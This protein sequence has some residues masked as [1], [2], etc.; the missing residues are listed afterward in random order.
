MQPILFD[1]AERKFTTNGIGRLNCI[2]CTVT[3]ERNGVYELEMVMPI[4]AEHYNE[5]EVGESVI[6]ARHDDTGD[7]QPFDV[8]EKSAPI[9]GK[10][11]FRAHHISYRLSD[12]VV[13]PYEA[14]TCADA[15]QQI[16]NQS[17]NA[18]PFTFWTDKAVSGNFVN[19]KPS[20]ARGMLAGNEGSILDVFG[21]GEYEFDKFTVKLHL[22]R[23]TDSGV[24][25]RYGK[26]LTDIKHDVSTGETYNAIVPFYLSNDGELVTLPE[27]MLVYEGA[28]IRTTYLT[29]HDLVIIRTENNEPIEVSY[30]MIDAVPMDLSQDFSDGA[31]TVEELRNAAIAKFEN[32]GAWEPKENI[33]VNFVQ[34]WQTDQFKEFAPLQRV[35]LCDTVSVFYDALGVN[36]VKKKVIKTVYNVLL[37]RY[38][39]IELGELSTSIA[40]VIAGPIEEQLANTPT[41]SM[42]DQ[43]IDTAT[44]LIRGGLGGY[45]VMNANADGK[46]EEILIMDKPDVNEA[47]QVIRMNKN[48]IAFSSTGYNGPFLSAWTIDGAFVAD[49]ITAGTLNAN[50]IRAG[51]IADVLGNTNW[52]LETGTLTMTKG[53]ITL[54]GGNFSVND[55]GYMEAISGL[56][57][58]WQIENNQLYSRSGTGSTYYEM[59][60]SPGEIINNS[61]ENSIGSLHDLTV[62]L[63]HGEIWMQRDSTMLSSTGPAYDGSNNPV[64]AVGVYKPYTMFMNRGGNIGMWYGGGS[65][66]SPYGAYFMFGQSVKVNAAFTVTGSKSREAATEDYADRLFYCY[67]MASPMFGDVGEGVIGEDGLAYITID[68]IFS[69]AVTLT[70]YQVFLQPYG[71]GDL[72]ID[73]REPSYFV[74]KGT[75]WL[76]FGW[77]LKAKQKGYEQTRLEQMREFGPEVVPYEEEAV[78]HLEEIKSSRGL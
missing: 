52:N 5:I 1:Y 53:S 17:A 70:Q 74:V 27:K 77:E 35:R 16:P 12:I 15:L 36:A 63:K 31:P 29:D 41:I 78:R 40:Q 37:E 72:H 58:G 9:D 67:E 11:T 75:P 22:H 48:G 73:T 7:M 47:V 55:S 59:S 44:Q 42:M 54:G 14:G 76:S 10:V 38:D 8:Y 69:E 18:N 65:G 26:N 24:E 39:S 45:V 60:I 62:S 56:I 28:T 4:T 57:A 50:V 43:A 32:S 33:D 46:P 61:H 34:L 21:T 51:V 49:F 20:L 30:R 3:E 68:P 23:G 19:E 66:T 64:T 71:E 25:I 13:M 6:L 2:E